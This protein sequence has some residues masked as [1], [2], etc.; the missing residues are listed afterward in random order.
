M[1]T[2]IPSIGP[3]AYKTLMA[4]LGL[5]QAEVAGRTGE[6][7]S[8]VANYLRL[9]D[10]TKPAQEMV[11]DGR[12]SMGHAKI[13][14]GVSDALEQERLANLVVSQSLSVRN[15]ERYIQEASTPKQRTEVGPSAHVVD[16]EKSLTQQLGMRV[17]VRGSRAKGKGKLILHYASLD[18]FDDLV[19]KLGVSVPS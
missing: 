6:D 3:L 4:Q 11:A 10:L 18:Q 1:K 19:L 12:L 7:R 16:L 13:L 17:Q 8:S 15:L 14:A 9:L 2:L 5:T